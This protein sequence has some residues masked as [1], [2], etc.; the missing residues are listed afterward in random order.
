M[1]VLAEEYL[2]LSD[3][4]KKLYRLVEQDFPSVDTTEGVDVVRDSKA[5]GE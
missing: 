4:D 3:E 1:G 5:V 2:S